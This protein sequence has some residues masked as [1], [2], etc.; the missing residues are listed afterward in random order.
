MSGVSVHDTSYI[1]LSKLHRESLEVQAHSQF[2]SY[3][4][5]FLTN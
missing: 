3:K 4:I 5:N 1:I 2:F